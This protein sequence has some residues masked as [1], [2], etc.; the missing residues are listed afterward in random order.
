MDT[1]RDEPLLYLPRREVE[2][3]C[4]EID[5]VRVMRE[6]FQM[7]GAGQTIL[8]E[9]AY[10]SWRNRD[11]E[12]VRSLN[13]P[14]YLGG[15][16]LV[17][18]TK[19]INGNGA[20]PQRGMPR[21]SG[22]T[23]LFDET[24]A[25]IVCMM[26]GAYISS[27]RTASVSV[28]AMELFQ[29]SAV[30]R[31]AVIGAGELAR[32]HL[33]LVS[34]RVPLL[35]EI[36][37][38]DLK[39]ERVDALRER[40]EALLR[41]RGVVLRSAGSAEDA[42][43]GAQ[44]VIAVTTT[45]CGYISYEWLQPG[46]LLVNVSLDDPLPEVVVKADQVIVDDWSLVKADARRLLGRMYRAGTLVGP[47]AVIGEGRRVDAQLGE[48]VRGEKAGRRDE[49]EIIMVNPFGLSLE[50]LALAAEV[51]RVACERSLGIWLER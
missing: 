4:R 28:L 18:G 13:M 10:L 44:V 27:L 16:W 49:R 41:A 9:E 20:N 23:L 42:I 21:A 25:R 30:E 40:M 7:H 26:E 36:A 5:S 34:E 17:A 1:Q 3:L 12:Q 11:A 15:S 29:S 46:A 35:R 48:I 38:F 33:E 2:L 22:M 51:Y 31:I 8:P 43:R 47:E 50:D 37:L 6:V 19:I 24:S 14:G 32:A 39:E 45:T